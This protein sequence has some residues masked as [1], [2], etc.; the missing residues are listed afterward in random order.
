MNEGVGT[1]DTRLRSCRA[2]DGLTAKAQ[3][4]A[5]VVEGLPVRGNRAVIP[6]PSV[7]DWI[8]S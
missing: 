4:L 7:S 3:T 5:A 8:S 6:V 2:E 1:A